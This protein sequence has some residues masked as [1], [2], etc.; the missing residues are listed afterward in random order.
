[1]GDLGNR[2]ITIPQSYVSG[3]VVPASNLNAYGMSINSVQNT[4]E[5]ISIDRN[6]IRG[7]IFGD[8]NDSNMYHF[9]LYGPVSGREVEGEWV[10]PIIKVRWG[11][12]TRACKFGN[13]TPDVDNFALDRGPQVTLKL[14]VDTFEDGGETVERK[15]QSVDL[16]LNNP[17][18]TE[19]S[20]VNY[21]YIE[22]RRSELPWEDPSRNPDY[23]I[24]DVATDESMEK[25][26][27]SM[28]KTIAEI[29]DDD[30]ECVMKILGY[31]VVDIAGKITSVKQ[32][33]NGGDIDD[34]YELYNGAFHHELIGDAVHPF[35]SKVKFNRG[36]ATVGDLTDIIDVQIID[37]DEHRFRNPPDNP[38]LGLTAI[39][40]EL[41]VCD[42]DSPFYD[43]PTLDGI[44]EIKAYRYQYAFEDGGIPSD[45]PID[46][47]DPDAY[48]WQQNPDDIIHRRI[49]GWANVQSNCFA[50]HIV[51]EIVDY[52]PDQKG[53]IIQHKYSGP[54]NAKWYADSYVS[55]GEG[56]IHG[57][58][59]TY[60]FDKEEIQ[61]D[62]TKTWNTVYIE[63][64]VDPYDATFD[65]IDL[66]YQA[67]AVRDASVPD[68]ED[69]KHKW[70]IGQAHID[71]T[72][73]T[74]NAWYQIQRGDLYAHHWCTATCSSPSVLT[75][76]I[77]QYVTSPILI[78]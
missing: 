55:I 53:S 78:P 11:L 62:V 16:I 49:L 56:E 52:T 18:E 15:Y 26:D 27:G 17:F 19:E 8:G 70:I 2:D 58:K 59:D 68:Q 7:M 23:L 48:N 67:N 21:I 1:M 36:V 73:Q 71:P 47:L 39:Y 72:T 41:K 31:V 66:K 13:F 77:G 14:D 44:K 12:W 28:T 76:Y 37:L 50:E 29:Q 4:G 74:V 69:E 6:P 46:P 5:Q 34:L 38:T 65:N 10:P 57:P 3:G 25:P 54:F 22:L 42:P 61:L 75:H 60:H 30:D 9:K 32:F 63:T 24:A 43:D 51:S 40:E 35:P 33:Y 45:Y 64:D 20:L